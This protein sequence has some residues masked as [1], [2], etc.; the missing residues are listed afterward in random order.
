MPSAASGDS[1]RNGEPGS[2][3]R[4]TRSRGSSFPREHAA[5]CSFSGPP[6]AA[7]ARLAARSATSARMAAALAL[8]SSE[9]VEMDDVI[10]GMLVPDGA[11]NLS[12]R[13]LSP[14]SSAQLCS[15][16][17]RLSLDPGHKARDDTYFFPSPGSVGPPA[18][19][20]ALK[21]PRM[22]AT[23]FSPMSCAVLAASAERRP[24]AQKNTNFLSSP[25]RS[26]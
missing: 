17:L 19:F 21:P 6:A 7:S 14:G 25:N 18:S 22:W 16:V 24:P 8:N 11:P 13:R 20:Q 9:E 2:I 5:R 15:G 12:S 26:L 10:F 23:G 4:S 1:S 3:S